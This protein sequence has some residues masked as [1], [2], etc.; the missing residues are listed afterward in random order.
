MP[1]LFPADVNLTTDFNRAQNAYAERLAYATEQRQNEL[2]SAGPLLHAE[3]FDFE[4]LGF[5]PGKLLSKQPASTKNKYCYW[6][7]EQGE[8]LT[9]RK[10]IDIP[11]QFYDEFFFIEEGL[12]KSCL[13]GN[14]KLLQNVKTRLFKDGRISEVFMMGGRGS[15]HETFYYESDNLVSIHVEQWSAE[16]VGTSYNTVFKYHNSQLHEIINEYDNGYREVRYK[17]R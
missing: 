10:G 7:N 12:S 8:V 1:A 15:K 5:A 4:R 14:T 2:W 16:Q 17:A 9:I 13:Y 6:L 3:P 11:D